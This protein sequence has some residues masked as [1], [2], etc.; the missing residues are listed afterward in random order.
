MGQIDFYIMAPCAMVLALG[1]LAWVCNAFRRWP[2]FLAFAAGTSLLA[3]FPYLF[4][5]GGGV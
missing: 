1:L 2:G 3:L 5:Y 4:V